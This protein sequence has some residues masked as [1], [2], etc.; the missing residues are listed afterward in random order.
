MPTAAAAST[1]VSDGDR[2][3][4]RNVLVL[5]TAQALGGSNTIIVVTTGGIVGAMLA[6]DKGLAT[7]PITM[8]VIG[9]WLGTLPVGAM[10][11]RFGRRF[12][13]QAGSVMGLFAGLI[14][15]LAVLQGS[16]GLFLLGTFCS[17]LYGASHQSYRFAA[18]DTA[19]ENFRAKAVSWVL[20]GGVVSALIG[21]QLIIFTK[22]LLPPFLFAATYLGQAALALLTALV[23]V[24]VKIPRPAP[25]TSKSGGRPLA[26]I[27]LT[28]RFIT[29]A[30]CGAVSYGMMNL[31]MTSAPLAMLA[32]DHSVTDA[33]LG[34]QWHVLSMYFPSFFTGGLIGRFGLNRIVVLGLALL[35]GSAL[36]AVSGITL[37][38]FWSAL[39]LLGVGWNFAFVGAT[40][41]VTQCYTAEERNKVQAFNDFLVFGSMALASF[42]SGQLLAKF[43]WT[44]VNEVVFPAVLAAA[45]LLLWRQLRE[46]KGA[47]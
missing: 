5:A 41:M 34:L 45:A 26:Q 32:C 9:M 13:L 46:R 38:H 43:G 31:V 17:G 12:A 44:A 25:V 42:S 7:L 3:A 24:F 22:E 20:A 10:A 1:H 29:A 4:R 8:M 47:A 2:L 19:S 21:P 14:C 35:F 28:P 37:L 33:T 40:T 23:L 15:Y 18:A 16:F 6:P 27:V 39:V 36:I 30:V 11:R